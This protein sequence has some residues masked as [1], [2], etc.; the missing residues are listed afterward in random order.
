MID[1]RQNRDYEIFEN[2]L[3]LGSAVNMEHRLAFSTSSNRCYSSHSVVWRET[4]TRACPLGR[5]GQG[6]RGARGFTIVLR[7]CVVVV[8]VVAVPSVALALW[9][10]GGCLCFGCCAV[11]AI[12][13]VFFLAGEGRKG[14]R[15]I[16]IVQRVCDGGGG[17]GSGCRGGGHRPL[18]WRCGALAV[19]VALVAVQLPQSGWERVGNGVFAV[20]VPGLRRLPLCNPGVGF[21]QL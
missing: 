8:V 1:P 17:G 19:A 10:F 20:S 13:V 4:V 14:L 21:Q 18:L 6:R 15:G 9:R 16:I 2:I 11:A 12:G 7:A 3:W 5:G